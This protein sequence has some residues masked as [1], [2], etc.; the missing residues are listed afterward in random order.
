ME[1][2]ERSCHWEAE[3][4][5]GVSPLLTTSL[6][7]RCLRENLVHI[8]GM[9]SQPEWSARGENLREKHL[10]ATRRGT[11]LGGSTLLLNMFSRTE[12]CELFDSSNGR[13][14][15]EMKP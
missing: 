9:C 13:I 15:M 5:E 1:S 14:S 3:K 11:V 10:L 4:E 12:Q 6:G 8:L 2:L 7:D